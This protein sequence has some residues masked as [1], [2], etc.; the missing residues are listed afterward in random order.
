MTPPTN[1]AGTDP[2][3]R[4][5]S[6]RHGRAPARWKRMMTMLATKRLR[7]SAVGRMTTAVMPTRDIAARYA[8]AP[9][10]PTEA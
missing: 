1:A 3:A 7:T 6:C 9:A 10:W 2:I 4:G 5:T 8:D